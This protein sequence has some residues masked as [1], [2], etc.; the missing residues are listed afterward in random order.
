MNAKKNTVISAINIV[1]AV[2]VFSR[3]LILNEIVE[4]KEYRT[5]PIPPIIPETNRMNSIMFP[6]LGVPAEMYGRKPPVCSSDQSTYERIA[7]I[8]RIET[9]ACC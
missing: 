7:V 8:N 2:V 9:V 6:T 3:F 1:V 4:T 5:A